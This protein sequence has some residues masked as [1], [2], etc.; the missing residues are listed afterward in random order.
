MTKPSGRP[1]PRRKD[2]YQEIVRLR[3]EGRP[4]ALAT[5]IS[6][7][8]S[9]PRKDTAKM[10]IAAD[11]TSVGSVGGGKVEAAVLETA[12]RVIETRH[13]ELLKYELNAEDAEGEHGH[14]QG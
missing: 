13:A 3:A 6:R 11:G 14:S 12:Q 9:V 8:G 7:V 10:L 4:A 5:I 1:A 2:L